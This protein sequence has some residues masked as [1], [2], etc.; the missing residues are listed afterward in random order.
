M[1]RYPGELSITSSGQSRLIKSQI[2]YLVTML[3]SIQHIN[4]FT[5]NHS[6]L[7][8]PHMYSHWVPVMRDTADCDAA[9]GVTLVT[10]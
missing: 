3:H 1:I 6:A 10:L 5:L 8:H 4:I 7:H 9:P 2:I